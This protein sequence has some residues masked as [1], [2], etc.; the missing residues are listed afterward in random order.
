[1]WTYPARVAFMFQST[2]LHEVRLIKLLRLICRNGFNPRT[3]MRCDSLPCN[4]I[5]CFSCFN[6]RTYMRCDCS[7]S[8]ANWSKRRFQSTHLHEVRPCGAGWSCSYTSFNPRTYMRCD[9]PTTLP[10]TDWSCFNPRT[11][12]RCDCDYDSMLTKQ[13]VSIHAPT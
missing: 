11:Y 7:S 6:P 10:P 1:M 5:Y 3:Y 8:R 13:L 4:Y 2:H 12:M 9:S